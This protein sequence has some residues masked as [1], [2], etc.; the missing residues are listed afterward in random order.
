MD[1]IIHK[2]GDG[3]VARDTVNPEVLVVMMGDGIGWDDERIAYE[4]GK[5]TI[6]P[7]E[8]NWPGLSTCLRS[9]MDRGAW[10][11]RIN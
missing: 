3:G 1:T 4:A 9:G 2:K 10:E 7:T 6:P 11:R 5:F 8:I